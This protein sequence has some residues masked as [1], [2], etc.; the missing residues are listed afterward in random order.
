MRKQKEDI[1]DEFIV[2][3]KFSPKVNSEYVTELQHSDILTF[4]ESK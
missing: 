3:L 2:P 1:T 4:Y